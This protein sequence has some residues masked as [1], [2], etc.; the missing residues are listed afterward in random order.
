MTPQVRSTYEIVTGAITAVVPK[1]SST[2]KAFLAMELME[3]SGRSTIFRLYTTEAAR[4]ILVW[5][6]RKFSYP[7]ELIEPELKLKRSAIVGLRGKILMEEREDQ[8][9][10]SPI[11]FARIGENELEERMEKMNVPVCDVN[12]DLLE[13]YKWIDEL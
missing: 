9:W 4:R 11:G 3:D 10:P 12:Q 5:F 7:D 6:L 1:T 8:S 13:E 2:G